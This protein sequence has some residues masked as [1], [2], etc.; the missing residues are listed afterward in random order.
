MWLKSSGGLIEAGRSEM[1]SSFAGC[2]VDISFHV[3]SHSQ[4]G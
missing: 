1:S 4:G 3:V 2:Q